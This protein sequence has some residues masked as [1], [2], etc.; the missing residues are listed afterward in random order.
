MKTDC[1]RYLFCEP[2]VAL[3]E[4]LQGRPHAPASLRYL[5][6]LLC[7]LYWSAADLL[8]Q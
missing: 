8:G 3:R 4:Y 6:D 1:G 2:A 7:F 5:F